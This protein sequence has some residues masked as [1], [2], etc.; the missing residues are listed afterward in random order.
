MLKN[1]LILTFFGLI[2][3]AYGNTQIL[4]LHAIIDSIKTKHPVVKMYDHEIRSMDEAAKG[5]RSWMPPQIGIGQFMTP[6][7]VRL[8]H[9]E[10][11]M[12]GMGSVMI[13][14]EQMLPNRKKLDADERYMKAMSS[15]EKEKKNATLNELVNDAKQF[16]YDWIILKKKLFI[17]EENEKILDFMIKNAEIRYKNG[18]EKI[19]AYYKAKA[20]LG[21]V[22]NMQLMFESDIKE[23]RIRINSLMGRNAMTD[24]DIDT[25]YFLNSYEA[26]VFDSTL[27]YTN[28][29]DL[30]SLDREIDLTIL[31]QETERT[32]L[33]PQFGIRYD[34]MI[35][36][37]GQP[38]QYTIMGMVRIP[39]AKWSSKMNKANIE[40]LKWKSNAIQSQKEMMVNEYSGMAYGMRNELGLKKKQ[41]K[42]FEGQ[43]IPA[44]RNN[45]KTMQL[46]YEQN[47]EELFMLY[48][49]WE[50]LNMKQLELLELLSQALKLQVTIERIIEKN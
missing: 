45:Y 1:K 25:T 13:S 47:T 38:L 9:R 32:A 7:D 24:F 10:G 3:F 20:A 34:N 30:K 21:E 36:F 17:L 29:S 23:K 37:G 22:K 18:L 16:Y 15:V 11:D 49:A 39:M 6:Y 12:P 19:S 35:G 5:A 44:L 43:I 27:F 42:L 33:K 48:D 31:K 4:K 40:S 28:R 14:G 46:G 50:I 41:L 26:L 2:C 8:W